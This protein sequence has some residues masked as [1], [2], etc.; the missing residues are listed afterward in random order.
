MAIKLKANEEE[1]IV[2]VPSSP[3]LIMAMGSCQPPKKR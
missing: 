2:L 1:K 3:T